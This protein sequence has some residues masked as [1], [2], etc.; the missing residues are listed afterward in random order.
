MRIIKI[1]IQT[2]LWK[3]HWLIFSGTM[4]EICGI[5]KSSQVRSFLY[6][7]IGL[8][9]II[10][11]VTGDVNTKSVMHS[12]HIT[13]SLP[14]IGALSKTQLR[15]LYTLSSVST[16]FKKESHA[17]GRVC[18][19]SWTTAKGNR[20]FGHRLGTTR[21][22]LQQ[23]VSLYFQ[24]RIYSFISF[25]SLNVRTGNRAASQHDSSDLR[26]Y[27]GLFDC[28]YCTSTMCRVWCV[29]YLLNYNN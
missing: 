23:K 3:Y 11:T 24:T 5:Q 16:K 22:I 28:L 29:Q 15:P 18:L 19:F 4:N 6:Y 13:C 25:L 10:I 1:T 21:R 27:F 20:G 26:S 14:K 8:H 7:D 9:C 17:E 12:L 2:S